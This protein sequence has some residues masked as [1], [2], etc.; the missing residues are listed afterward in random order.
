VIASAIVAAAA[1]DVIGADGALPWHLPADLRRFQALTMGH[2]LVMGRLTHESILARLGRPLPGRTSV[3][4]T[5][6][7]GDGAGSQ[8][9]GA[10]VRYAPSVAAALAAARDL[11]AAAGQQEFFVIGGAAVLRQALGSVDRIYLTRIHQDFDG[12]RYLPAGCLDGFELRAAE[13]HQ[14]GQAAGGPGGGLAFSFLDYH[15]AR[16]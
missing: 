3:V 13:H 7:G 8:A 15:R 6:G 4:I 11:A 14:A 2:V 9:G 5:S 16:T 1:N 10:A 12:D